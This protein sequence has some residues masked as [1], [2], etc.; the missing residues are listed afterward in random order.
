MDAK[1]YPSSCNHDY[2]NTTHKKRRETQIC[3]GSGVESWQILY[4]AINYNTSYTVS[5][6]VNQI[7]KIISKHS[8]RIQR[9]FNEK[10]L[11]FFFLLSSL[12]LA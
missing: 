8:D 4:T 5:I 7:V 11:D 9:T 3:P 10:A 1:S 2:V 6:N 12:S